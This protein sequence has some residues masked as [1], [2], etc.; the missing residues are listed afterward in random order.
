M[1]L[2]FLRE[3][4]PFQM[5]P[6]ATVST[7]AFSFFSLFLPFFLPPSL[8]S[9]LS[10]SHPWHMEVPRLGVKSELQLPA[11]TTATAV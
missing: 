10:F 1:E 8:P 7:T 9:F 4:G 6:S 5:D 3:G 2:S 11:Y